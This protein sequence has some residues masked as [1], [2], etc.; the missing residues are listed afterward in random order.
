MRHARAQPPC[1]P[2]GKSITSDDANFDG[3]STYAGSAKGVYRQKPLEVGSFAPNAFG[4][5][6]MH[7]NVW[8]W[9]A[10]CY[11][12]NYMGA[13]TDGSAAPD[14]P[15]CQR[16]MRGGSWID[17]PRLL[18]SAARGHV[19]SHTRFIYRGFRVARV[20]AGEPQS[21]P[22]GEKTVTCPIVPGYGSG[23]ALP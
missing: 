2:P 6:D 20:L 10:D 19:P 7:G 15:N 16:V 9:I 5:Y 3:T 21:A 13:P 12:T 1:S 4:L 22:T 11:T 14:V 18:R 23:E 8:E 17:S